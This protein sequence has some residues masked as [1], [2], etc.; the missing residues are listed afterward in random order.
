M[1]SQSVADMIKASSGV[2]FSGFHMDGIESWKA[3]IEQPTTSTTAN[4]CNQPFIIGEFIILLT[5]T[6]G[7]QVLELF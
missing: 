1:G 2:H 6:I 3:D 5:C 4:V 7:K